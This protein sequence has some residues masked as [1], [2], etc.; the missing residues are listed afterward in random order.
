MTNPLLAAL[1]SL[2]ADGEIENQ[3]Y[4]YSGRYMYGAHCVA[5]NLDNA[6]ELFMLGAMLAKHEVDPEIPN[7]DS[8]GRGIVAY[9]PR[10]VISPE[11]APQDEEDDD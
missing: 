8:M 3:P 2:H 1:I 7:T 9:W 10:E 11:D 5:I 4:A 6:G